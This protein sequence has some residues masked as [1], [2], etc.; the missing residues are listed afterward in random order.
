MALNWLLAGQTWTSHLPSWP[1]REPGALSLLQTPPPTLFLLWLL[2][3]E[4]QASLPPSLS[5]LRSGGKITPCVGFLSA[6]SK[7]SP[8]PCHL[9]VLSKGHHPVADLADFPAHC[10]LSPLVA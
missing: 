1:R 2:P 8:P 9:P 4:P 7:A 5:P 10:L 6:S 3:R